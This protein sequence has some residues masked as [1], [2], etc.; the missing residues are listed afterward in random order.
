[1]TSATVTFYDVLA[2]RGRVFSLGVYRRVINGA[3]IGLGAVAAA[4]TLVTIVTVAAAWFFNAALATNPN[5]HVNTP[6]VLTNRYTTIASPTDFVR[7]SPRPAD[8]MTFE[9]KWARAMASVSTRTGVVLL[10]P[11]HPVERANNVAA[12]QPSPLGPSQS[13][14]A[15]SESARPSILMHPPKLIPERANGVPLPRPHPMQREIAVSP[16]GKAE[17]QV[18]AST[19]P[20]PTSEK[21]VV[22]QEDH[23]KSMSPPDPDSRT[24]IYD[25]SARTVYLPNGEK[26]EA[27]SGLGDKLDDPQYV[28][29]RMWGP[30]PPN[31]YDLTLRE[32]L[33]HGVRAIRLNPVDDSQMFGRDGILAHS[34][35]LGPNG[36][37]NGCVSF[38][39][40]P[41]FLQ[42]FLNGEVDRL[43]VVPDLGTEP[44]RTARASHRHVGRYAFNN[45]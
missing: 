6:I 8:A 39:D 43:V 13:S 9:V 3:V 24:A 29:V 35:M 25:I 26:L 4:C 41:K 2:L 16:S 22:P 33:F 10:V 31:V 21:R 36:Q 38:K 32:K 20:P 7:V 17:P 44:S 23:N 27:H 12:L 40:Y 18:A 37:S 15:A 34:Y 42:A 28:H 19:P 30:T 1:M 14:A 45:Q 11:Q 5:L